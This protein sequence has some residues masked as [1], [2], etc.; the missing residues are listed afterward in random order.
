MYASDAS[1]RTARI[2]VRPRQCDK[3]RALELM[4]LLRDEVPA[5]RRCPGN[6]GVFS[7]V[8][9]HNRNLACALIFAATRQPL[10]D[11]LE[12]RLEHRADATANDDN[13]RL[14]QVNDI[15]K[16][17]RQVFD[18]LIQNLSGEA[19]SFRKRLPH[20]FTGHFARLAVA[21]GKKNAGIARPLFQLRLR[22]ACNCR[23]SRERLDASALAASA[24]DSAKIDADV[25]AFA[26]CSRSSVKDFSIEHNA[27]ADSGSDG[28]VE[29]I[30]KSVS[31]AP[32]RFRQSRGV[33]VVVQL[34]RQLKG[35]RDS[36]G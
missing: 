12:Q 8:G 9:R 5:K 35:F 16:P 10:A 24:L 15:A 1:M 19:I 28:C 18:R 33:G 26:R 30:L 22:R 21:K 14:E 31:C 29:D 2:V 3:T 11:S 17:M 20:H 27:G 25:P 7:K 4:S 34:H 36:L 32:D 13:L 6:S 23:T